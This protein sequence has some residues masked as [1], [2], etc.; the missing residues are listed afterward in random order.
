[1]ST[2]SGRPIE[3]TSLSA[4]IGPVS[5]DVQDAFKHGWTMAQVQSLYDRIVEMTNRETDAAVLRHPQ[6]YDRESGALVF[7]GPKL[8]RA[9]A[10]AR[11]GS[12]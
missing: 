11:K 4:G 12:R 2:E 7:V 9:R 3:P 10:A 5:L 1:M 6:W 8:Q